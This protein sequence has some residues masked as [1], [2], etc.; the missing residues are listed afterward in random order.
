M[1][2]NITYLKDI[3]GSNY[4][5]VKINITE[6]QPFLNQLQDILGESFDEYVSNQQKRD[7]GSYHITVINVIDYNNLTKQ[8]G[9]DKFINSLDQVMKANIDDIKLLGLGSAHKNENTAYFVV[10]KSELL[11]EVLKMYGLPEKD[12]HITL[13]F[14]HKDVHGVRKNEILKADE[15]FLS[16]LKKEYVKEGETF[17][18][19]KG[20]KNF[21]YDFFKLIEPISINDTT[22]TFRCG[23]ND[24]FTVGL[25]ENQ[26]YITAKWQDTEK[27]PI[28]SDVLINKK[29]KENVK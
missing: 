1:R 18:F 13:G 4:L 17:E 24:Y 23:D 2:H 7:S 8:M 26:F 27:K 14:K 28:L 29:L 10:V 15:P 11:Q 5:G 3:L 6:V 12:L 25:I 16:R 22:A 19:V 21:D 9:M 20:I